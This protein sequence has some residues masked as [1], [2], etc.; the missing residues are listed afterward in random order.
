[1][2]K[3]REDVNYGDETRHDDRRCLQLVLAGTVCLFVCSLLMN[4]L[5]YVHLTAAIADQTATIADQRAAI[6]DLSHR[7]GDVEGR[8]DSHR[9]T[10]DLN[11]QTAKLTDVETGQGNIRDSARNQTTVKDTG[12]RTTP[13]ANRKNMV[14]PVFALKVGVENIVKKRHPYKLNSFFCFY[15]GKKILQEQRRVRHRKK[16]GSP[17]QQLSLLSVHI[18]A[19]TGSPAKTKE[20]EGAINVTGIFTQWQD[21]TDRRL[22]LREGQL[23][24]KESGKY[25]IYSQIDF[26]LQDDDSPVT[27]SINKFKEAKLT[28]VSPM[29]GRKPRH[30]CYTAGVLDLE[31]GDRLVLS[32][33]CHATCWVFTYYDTTFWGAIKLST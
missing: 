1:M 27:Y 17:Q 26:A 33:Q 14:T 16:F 32:I 8:Q 18:P 22:G 7:L 30:T 5:V 3:Y 12:A 21:L 20:K 15:F 24:I 31:K 29:F 9:S 4:V 25:F 23:E 2:G 6:A 11:R 19:R 28:C 13:H 10:V